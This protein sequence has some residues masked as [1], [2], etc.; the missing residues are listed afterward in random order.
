MVLSKRNPT[1]KEHDGQSYDMLMKEAAF[2]FIF[3]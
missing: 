2:C 3:Q 1:T